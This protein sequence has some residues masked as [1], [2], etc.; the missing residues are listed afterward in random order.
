MLINKK[1]CL[2]F[3][4]SFHLS[5]SSP[6]PAINPISLSAS[7]FLYLSPYPPPPP[8]PPLRTRYISERPTWYS[9]GV[10]YSCVY[11]TFIHMVGL[12]MCVSILDLFLNRDG[13]YL[14]SFAL[15]RKEPSWDNGTSNQDSQNFNDCLVC[16]IIVVRCPDREVE[17]VI[18]YCRPVTSASGRHVR[19]GTVS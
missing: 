7:P 18:F 10:R 9:Q 4:L 16:S 17:Y 8:P 3:S 11:T 19:L 6:L 14:D 1:L 2:L 13:R 12:Y 5:P 15:G